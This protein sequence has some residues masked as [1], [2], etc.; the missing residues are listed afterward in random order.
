MPGNTGARA[1]MAYCLGVLGKTLAALSEN[2]EARKALTQARD[3]W[4]ELQK[5]SPLTPPQEASLTE[6]QKLLFESKK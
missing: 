4:K 3:I 2:E 1:E 5:N 6:I